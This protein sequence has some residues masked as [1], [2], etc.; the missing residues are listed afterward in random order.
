MK[1]W[2]KICLV[3][4]MT[5]LMTGGGGRCLY[6]GEFG[7]FDI[8]IGAEEDIFEN[9]E[10][11][12]GESQETTEPELKDSESS[13]EEKPE[14][15]N[16]SSNE[17]NNECSNESSNNNSNVSNNDSANSGGDNSHNNNNNSN[18]GEASQSKTESSGKSS[19][20]ESSADA[21][22]LANNSA[23]NKKTDNP[24]NA[25][26]NAK[27]K[28]FKSKEETLNSAAS[29]EGQSLP[30]EKKDENPSKTD[31]KTINPKIPKVESAVDRRKFTAFGT[32]TTAIG[33]AK[34]SPELKFYNSN[35]ENKDN[36]KKTTENNNKNIYFEHPEFVP[37][38]EYP[39]IRIIRRAEDQDVTI[40]SLRF[41]DEEIFFHQEGDTLIFDQPVTG[42]K[43][44][45]NLLAVID[46]SRIVQMP[47]WEF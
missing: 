45:I 18:T 46:G 24:A 5:L 1:R 15:D 27:R 36:H 13:R 42:K 39:R 17:R 10:E 16:K 19:D 12:S 9:W 4:I 44:R 41:N 35:D 37:E 32:V 28:D 29:S 22:S 20:T 47:V 43:N 40:L 38:N 23:K 3:M 21:A 30:S 33:M 8:D 31:E 26:D 14:S 34:T 11:G 7:G 25:N 6:A 2:T